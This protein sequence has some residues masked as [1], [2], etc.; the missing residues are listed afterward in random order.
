FYMQRTL[1]RGLS[2]ESLWFPTCNE[3]PYPSLCGGSEIVTNHTRGEVTYVLGASY[4][5]PN[6]YRLE[7]TGEVL[8]SPG[9]GPAKLLIHPDDP[10]HVYSTFGERGFSESIDGGSTWTPVDQGLPTGEPVAIFMRRDRPEVFQFVYADGSIHRSLDAARSW[11]L[12]S[13]LDVGTSSITRATWDPSSGHVFALT[14]DGR[15]LSTWPVDSADLP[16]GPVS[17]HYATDRRA[18]L[19]GTSRNGLFE[20]PLRVLP[21]VP[22][23]EIAAEPSRDPVSGSTRQVLSLSP[24]PTGGP[25]RVRLEGLDAR[26]AR[27]DVFDARGRLVR[28][29]LGRSDHSGSTSVEWDGR[30]EVGDLVP[31]GVYFVRLASGDL[32]EVRKVTVIR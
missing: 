14:G 26:P 30:S 22:R 18:L 9:H 21:V 3:D 12:T 32:T 4:P 27:L 23:S 17:I 8:V 25:L 13:T 1:D 19:V 7:G 2:W 20:R 28:R 29:L 5:D 11:E 16:R 31:S 15:L 6:L 10:M 24:N